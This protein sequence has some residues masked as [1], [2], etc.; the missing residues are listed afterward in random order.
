MSRKKLIETLERLNDFLK[1]IEPEAKKEIIGDR[2]FNFNKNK[3]QYFLSGAESCINELKMFEPETIFEMK[4]A[5]EREK[6]KRIKSML[7]EIE[8]SYTEKKKANVLSL[9]KDA[10]KEIKG[11]KEK[12]T[13]RI[14]VPKLPPEI[15][16]DVSL[17][18][19]EIERCFNAQCF[20][21]VTILCGR[22]LETAFTGSISRLQGM[23]FLKRS[24]E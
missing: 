9:I 23:I 17:D 11:M 8:K 15:S 20:R 12:E 16:K 2:L 6:A 10:E 21:S 22:V 18:L 5:E 13:F 19:Q 7:W 14:T 3:Q 4:T 24:Q 1:K